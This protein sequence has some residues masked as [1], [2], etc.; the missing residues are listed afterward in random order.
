MRIDTEELSYTVQEP[1]AIEPIKPEFPYREG[2][3]TPYLSDPSYLALP[4]ILEYAAARG[5][6][7]VPSI[8]EAIIGRQKA[9]QV[10]SIREADTAARGKAELDSPLVWAAI[11]TPLDKEAAIYILEDMAGAHDSVFELR[12]YYNRGLLFFSSGKAATKTPEEV[13]RARDTMIRTLDMLRW[14]R[15]PAW[16][17]E[18][19]KGFP[20]EMCKP[21]FMTWTQ[22]E[23]R[24][25]QPG[26]KSDHDWDQYRRENEYVADNAE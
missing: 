14:A 21:D 20:V 7:V 19:D 24:K 10:L 11:S 15:V 26:Q 1:K 2:E 18:I 13:Q 3:V 25:K 8:K 6:K 22:Y 16:D 4:R 12:A 17:E 9:E 23:E 5:Y